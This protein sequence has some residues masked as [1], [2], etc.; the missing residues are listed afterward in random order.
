MPNPTMKTTFQKQRTVLSFMAFMGCFSAYYTH[1]E[2][3]N[4]RSHPMQ[5]I[6]EQYSKTPPA[7][8]SKAPQVK[9]QQQDM[10][11][12]HIDLDYVFDRDKKQQERNIQ[13]LIQ[14][15]QT[16][17]PNT[18][19]L[20]AFADPDGNGSADQVYFK[21]RH[22]PVREN[23]FA[24][25]LQDIRKHTAVTNIYA[26]MPLLAWEFPS[27]YNIPYVQTKAKK[28]GYVRISPFDRT[29]LQYS[30][31]I[32]LDLIQQHRLE[33][34]LYHDDITLSDF[35]DSNPKAMTVYEAWGFPAQK[36]IAQP[37]HAQQL[38]LS[39]HKTAYLDQAA[40]SVSSILKQ[41]QPQLRFARNM[42]AEAVLNPAS[43]KWFSQSNASTY[44]H[45]DY[46]AIMAMPYMEKAENHREFYLK[47]IAQ[48][49]KYDPDLSR[50]IFELQVTD[51][52]HQ[53]QISDAEL[54]DTISL[55]KQHGV[56]HIGYYPDDFVQNHPS[57]QQ[58]KTAFAQAE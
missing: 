5:R 33:G 22:I 39:Q 3:V 52:H 43:E 28:K 38:A 55:L 20:Q 56:R 34:I 6:K 44:K 32:F 30:T 8:A 10:R 29:N 23:I 19:F 2:T 48:A 9:T 14:R 1:A 47:L 57:A 54:Q 7:F 49:K 46:N 58:L 53:T 21:N 12:M 26:W 45:Y 35:E 15:I 24:R 11:I 27:K 42:Y 16:I 4:L 13:A 40:Q 25:V 17:A 37:N 50:T 31:E 36:M 41:Q 18:V 51:W